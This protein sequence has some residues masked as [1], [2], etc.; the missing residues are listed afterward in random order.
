MLLTL[1]EV[2]DADSTHIFLM[3]CSSTKMGSIKRQATDAVVEAAL[4]AQRPFA[5]S[6]SEHI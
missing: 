4:T 1:V 2:H 5:A 3:Y 6:S